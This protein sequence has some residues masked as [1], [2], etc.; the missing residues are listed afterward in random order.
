MNSLLHADVEKRVDELARKFATA[1]PFR[2]VV[3]EPFL[4]PAVYEQLLAEFPPFAAEKALNE[5]GEVAG[6][7]V[8][9]N[10]PQLG[11]AYKDFDRLM[12]DPAFL[13]LAGRITGIP[14]LLYDA[15]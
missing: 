2:H 10:L 6:K 9:S 11:P 14:G 3:I 15:E 13:S 8:F 5:S 1:Q 4:D 12:Q 7:A